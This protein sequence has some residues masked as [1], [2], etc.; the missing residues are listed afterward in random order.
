LLFAHLH[1]RGQWRRGE[2]IDGRA[3]SPGLQAQVPGRTQKQMHVG[4]VTAADAELVGERSRIGRNA[5]NAR[6]GAQRLQRVACGSRVRFF[7]TRARTCRQCGGPFYSL[8]DQ[9]PEPWCYSGK[10]PRSLTRSP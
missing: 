8:H 10:N 2:T 7:D 9:L 6:H 1:E 4:A 3:R 5:M